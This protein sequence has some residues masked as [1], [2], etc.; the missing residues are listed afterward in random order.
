MKPV[1]IALQL[2]GVRILLSSRGEEGREATTTLVRLLRE[3]WSTVISP[4]GPNGP[5]G[6]LKKGVLHIAIESQVPVVPVRLRAQ[7]A[8]RLRS[9]DKKPIP[10]PFS[11]IRIV[12]DEP[13]TVTKSS[14]DDA[15]EK[16]VKR[17]SGAEV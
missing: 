13:V 5:A 1:H 16:L 14:F 6:A 2:M 8:V 12:F 7:R 10:L 3:G 15:G 17:M 9:W 4:D 11:R